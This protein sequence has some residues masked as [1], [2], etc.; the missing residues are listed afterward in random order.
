MILVAVGLYLLGIALFLL[1]YRA[2]VL[3]GWFQALASAAAWP[4]V[5]VIL[6]LGR[7]A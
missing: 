5:V 2:R 3:G 4:M 1:F 7:F 6:T